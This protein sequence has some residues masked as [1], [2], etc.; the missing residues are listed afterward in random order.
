[1][2][3]NCNAGGLRNLDIMY[4]SELDPTWNIDEL[5]FFINPETVVFANQPLPPVWSIVR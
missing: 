2:Q 1:V 5:A 3:N 4:M